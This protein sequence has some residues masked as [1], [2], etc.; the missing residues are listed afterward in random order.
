M[1]ELLLET[2]LDDEQRSY[3]EQVGSSSEHMLAIINDILDI[4]TIETGRLELDDVEFDLRDAVE[5]ACA[6][7]ALEARA[8][9]IELDVEIG[10]EVPQQVIGDVSRLR[11]VLMNLVSNAAKFTDAGSVKVRLR[12]VTDGSSDD[13]RFEISDSGIGIDPLELERMFEPF[14]QADV[15]TTRTYG[16]NGLGLAIAKELVEL[17][18][19]TI[20][21]ESEPGAGS[22]FWFELTLPQGPASADTPPRGPAAHSVH[23]SVDLAAR[24]A[25]RSV[26]S[27]DVEDRRVDPDA[28]L[29]LVVEDSPVNR[30]VAGGVLERSGF[31]AHLVDDAL[32]A[33][34]ALAGQR[35]DAVLMDCQMPGMDG[36][37]ATREL[38]RRE[39]GTER[40]TPVIAM[41]AHAM[42]GDRARCLDAGMDD[43]VTKPVSSKGLVEVLRR[44]VPAKRADDPTHDGPRRG[45]PAHDEPPPGQPTHDELRDGARHALNGVG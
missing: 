43:Y 28:A 37:E 40:H 14:T 36:Y 30:I 13:I 3:A 17:M 20:G 39:S 44:W 12:R 25:Q 8:K 27:A 38:R 9:S 11:Q 7:A 26:E 10:T 6:P 29:V 1:N 35:Y 2:Q 16:G 21:A 22:T 31:R 45:E 5:Q 19:G 18:G 24:P 34:Q 15:S 42:T 23:A 4:S 32:E 33:L 41:T